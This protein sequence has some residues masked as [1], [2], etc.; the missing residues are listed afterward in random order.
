M[1]PDGVHFNGSVNLADTETVF[2]ELAAR[3]GDL[4]DAYP[5]GETGERANWVLFQGPHLA[6]VDGLVRAASQTVAGDQLPQLRVADGVNVDA[7]DF[8]DVGY[9]RA[10]AA[11]YQT[12][13]RLRDQRV[14]PAGTRFQVQYPTPTAV[15]TAHIDPADHERVL[16]GYERALFDDLAHLLD[17][18]PHDEVQL[19]WDVAVEI[20]TIEQTGS[21]P[22]T[23]ELTRRLARCV[24]QVPAD[25]PV[26]LHLCY[27]DYKH[28]HL[29]EPTSL[30]TQIDVLTR[31]RRQARRSIDRVAFTVP[32]YQHADTYFQPLADLD[33]A[34]TRVYFGIVPYHPDEQAPDTTARQVSLIDRY[35]PEW[36][37]STECGMGR[38]EAAEAPT[39]LD[40]HRTII[41][42][43]GHARS[44]P[45]TE[46]T[47]K[48]SRSPIPQ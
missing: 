6:A 11:S 33:P 16:A 4:A 19:Q 26:G 30:H 7:L 41:E 2:R 10:Y 23:E 8:G 32:Q 9:A 47:S 5:D 43:Y 13:R 18:L 48:T 22:L 27:G 21:A 1:P 35:L 14:I 39:L 17:Q 31:T 25:V 44:L 38:A 34:P 37:I 3:V 42:T 28:R 46:P 29:I 24:D 36:G 15:L 20:V 12:F 40:L 45:G